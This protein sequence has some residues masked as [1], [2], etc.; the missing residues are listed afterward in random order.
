MEICD[1]AFCHGPLM[2]EWTWITGHDMVIPYNFDLERAPTAELRR[3][4][5]QV[6]S[7]QE[8]CV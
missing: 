5:V 8:G 1:Q 7:N 3:Q 2:V 6:V 4:L